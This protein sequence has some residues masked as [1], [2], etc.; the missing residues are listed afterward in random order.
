MAAKIARIDGIASVGEGCSQP[1]VAIRMFGKAVGHLNRCARGSI[2]Q[3]S[4]HPDRAA[5]ALDGEG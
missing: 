1:L 3:P 2:R 5:V 4:Q